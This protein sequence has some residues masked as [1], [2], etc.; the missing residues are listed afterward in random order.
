MTYDTMI[1]IDLAKN[2]FQVHGA[3]LSGEV[4]FRRK[5]SRQ[6]F[7]VC[8]RAGRFDSRNGGLRDGS[9]LVTRT[10]ETRP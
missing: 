10:D 7:L 5:L 9:L 4:K 3:L 8:S 2:V 1:G 6:H